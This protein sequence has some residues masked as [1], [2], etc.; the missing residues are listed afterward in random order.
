MV[1][2]IYWFSTT[3]ENPSKL[4]DWFVLKKFNYKPRKYLYPRQ[5]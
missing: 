2:S 3:S 1:I 5:L 4:S